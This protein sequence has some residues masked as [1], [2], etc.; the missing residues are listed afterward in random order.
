MIISTV[1]YE[2]SSL[3]NLFRKKR[4]SVKMTG[5]YPRACVRFCQ[6]QNF[7]RQTRFQKYL[8][9][10][11]NIAAVLFHTMGMGGVLGMECS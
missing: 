11:E 4:K 10:R 2:F 6:R 8:C 9:R 7:P 3:W 5:Q 1:N